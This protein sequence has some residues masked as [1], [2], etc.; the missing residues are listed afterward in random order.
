[1][2]LIVG[3]YVAT[4]T[5]ATLS[6]ASATISDIASRHGS[7]AAAGGAIALQTSGAGP[8]NLQVT[9]PAH[10]KPS[11]LKKL[12]DLLLDDPMRYTSPGPSPAA[13]SRSGNTRTSP[14]TNTV[15]GLVDATGGTVPAAK[16]WCNG[17]LAAHRHPRGGKPTRS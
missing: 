4:A 11:E 9:V 12:C 8:G 17:F 2:R 3:K 5:V 13:S 7:T 15:Q 16:T 6:V 14:Y 1:L 10:P